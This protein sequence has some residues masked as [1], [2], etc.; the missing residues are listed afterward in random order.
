MSQSRKSQPT[1]PN[2]Q[3]SHRPRS[4]SQIPQIPNPFNIQIVRFQQFNTLQGYIHIG[5]VGTDNQPIVIK[6]TLKELVEEHKSKTGHTIHENFHE[7]KRILLYL[8][9]Q[10]DC[11]IGICRIHTNLVWEDYQSYYYSMQFCKA[12]LFEYI[13]KEFDKSN[14]SATMTKIINN[15]QMNKK[16]YMPWITKIQN[17]FRQICRS[18]GYLHSKGI[19]HLDLSLENALLFDDTGCMIKLIDFGVAHDISKHNGSWIGKKRVGKINYMPPEVYLERNFDC[20]KVDVW[21]LG[22]MLFMCLVG[23]PPYARPIVKRHAR[24]TKGDSGL[25]FLIHGRIETILT[26]WKRIWMVSD[27]AMDL[28]KKIFKFE[29]KRISMNELLCHPFVGLELNCNGQLDV[30]VCPHITRTIKVL[31]NHNAGLLNEYNFATVRLLND[32]NHIL[33]DHINQNGKQFDLIYDLLIKNVT[34]NKLIDINTSN[35]YQRLYRNRCI[36]EDDNKK[37]NNTSDDEDMKD[38][39]ELDDRLYEITQIAVLDKIYCYF[40]YSKQL[41]NRNYLNI[42]YKNRIQYEQYKFMTFGWDNNVSGDIKDNDNDL[43]M[44][45]NTNNDQKDNDND[46]IIDD[47][48]TM[49]IQP[50]NISRG[51][52]SEQDFYDITTPI[53]YD[54]KSIIAKHLKDDTMGNKEFITFVKDTVESNHDLNQQISNN[55]LKLILTQL[56]DTNMDE[57]YFVNNMSAEKFRTKLMNITNLDKEILYALYREI[58]ESINAISRRKLEGL[59]SLELTQLIYRILCEE[60]GMNMNNYGDDGMYNYDIND[61]QLREI[62]ISGNIN[63]Y[64]LL[65]MNDSEICQLLTKCVYCYDNINISHT[66]GKRFHFFHRQNKRFI[67][68]IYNGLELGHWYVTKKYN[69]LKKEC[70]NNNIISLPVKEWKKI[71]FYIENVLIHT[72]QIKKY[73]TVSVVKKNFFNEISRVAH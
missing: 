25:T 21:C 15:T 35:I 24:D 18:V 66:F 54:F 69:N 14:L 62:F 71:L 22:V 37:N 27:D 30:N 33:Q 43:N 16:P 46:V 8:S 1:K 6:E 40:V 29:D 58:R 31:V 59:D 67:E 26:A 51:V 3:Q 70:L 34:D 60:Y 11:D 12:G 36:N 56:N 55:E 23:S 65:S 2:N 32:F 39:N 57:I 4:Y 63:G 38:Q 41:E 5:I 52:S 42:A 49:N 10:N 45:D 28:L 44:I 64:K 19:A 20:R 61:M 7:E 73:I 53:F 47:I 13:H 9:N 48:K 17:I 50:T 68:D 72:I